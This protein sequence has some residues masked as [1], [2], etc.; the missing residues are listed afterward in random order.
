MTTGYPVRSLSVPLPEAQRLKA[1]GFPQEA[2][3]VD[4]ARVFTYDEDWRRR[5]AK[6]WGP[7]KPYAVPY[8]GQKRFIAAPDPIEALLWLEQERFDHKTHLVRDDLRYWK[9]IT[10]HNHA[11]GGTEV[12]VASTNPLEVLRVALELIPDQP[13]RKED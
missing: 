6:G 5:E 2:A 4:G 12:H 9:V 8:R 10:I 7:W 13:E 3:A 11:F 1:K